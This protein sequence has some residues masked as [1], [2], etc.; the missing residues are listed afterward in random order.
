MASCW[1]FAS[2]A[3]QKQHHLDTATRF[4]ACSASVH[5]K[6][7]PGDSFHTILQCDT[8][9]FSGRVTISTQSWRNC[10]QHT[11]RPP[12]QTFS[13]LF[14]KRREEWTHF[15][16]LQASME[17]FSHA[18]SFK[19]LVLVS[20]IFPQNDKKNRLWAKEQSSYHKALIKNKDHVF[21]LSKVST[22]VH[23]KEFQ[24]LLTD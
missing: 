9:A 14:T 21:H 10:G 19:N 13:P 12:S 1:C 18:Q 15:P 7:T 16:G 2:P 24:R 3:K 5:A 8:K 4:Q 17:T 22:A 6:T 23:R 20:K 11:Q